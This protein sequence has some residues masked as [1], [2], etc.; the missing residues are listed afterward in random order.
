MLSGRNWTQNFPYMASSR[1]INNYTIGSLLH[2]GSG[3]IWLHLIPWREERKIGK[4]RRKKGKG[5]E[6][7]RKKR[8]RRG[9]GWE[10][11]GWREGVRRGRIRR[12]EWEGDEWEGGRMRR[13]E[14]HWLAL[15]M[16]LHDMYLNIIS[17]WNG[18]RNPSSG[19]YCTSLVMQIWC[20]SMLFHT[21]SLQSHMY[22]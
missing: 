6:M 9:E 19:I 17:F 4:R 5:Q 14:H 8:I 11:G 10:G 15:S 18:S 7:R 1:H 22:V 3:Y 2:L 12:E 16:L 20:E 21:D 13:G